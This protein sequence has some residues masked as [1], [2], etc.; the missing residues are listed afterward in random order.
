MRL[1]INY[2]GPRDT[3]SSFSFADLLAGRVTAD[4]LAGRIVLIG[5]SST[6]SSDSFAQPFGSS[7]ASSTWPTSSTQ[8][9]IAIS[10]VSRRKIGISS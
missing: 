8:S 9:S 1:L 5:A 7:Q 6:G 2:R 4:Q 10:S 3:F